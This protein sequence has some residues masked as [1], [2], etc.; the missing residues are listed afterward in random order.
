MG[1]EYFLIIAFIL[2]ILLAWLGFAGCNEV[3]DRKNDQFI[4]ERLLE[5][6]R[7]QQYQEYQQQQQQKQEVN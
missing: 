5:H 3:I 4:I 7:Q 6:K 2:I 1:L